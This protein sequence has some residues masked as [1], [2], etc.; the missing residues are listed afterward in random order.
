M[1]VLVATAEM[2]VVYLAE[3]EDLENLVAIKILRDALA[4]LARWAGAIAVEERTL[5]K[6]ESSVYLRACTTRTQRQT[7]LL[8]CDGVRGGSCRWVNIAIAR[9][10]PRMRA[11]APFFARRCEAVVYAHQHAVI[12]PRSEAFQHSCK[13]R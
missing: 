5:A 10:V 8:F 11:A 12:H 3:R 7:E 9:G 2:G 1:K 6:A 4:I 13:K